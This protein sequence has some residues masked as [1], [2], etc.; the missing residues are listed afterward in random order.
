MTIEERLEYLEQE[1]ASLK[2][3]NEVRAKKFVLEDDNG[4]IRALLG[5]FDGSTGL[6]FYDENGIPRIGLGI[7]TGLFFADEEN[8]VH[9]MLGP[10]SKPYLQLSAENAEINLFMSSV[11]SHLEFKDEKGV[12]RVI[13]GKLGVQP[14]LF[15]YDENDSIRAALTIKQ[16]KTA[17]LMFND[18]GKH[19]VTLSAVEDGAT[20]DLGDN[21]GNLRIR[22]SGEQNEKNLKILGPDGKVIWRAP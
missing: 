13:L 14:T 7:E 9:L 12:S 22:L 3:A 11:G 20:L 4:E 16:G 5:F 2:E 8:D 18:K 1:L 19:C 21:N 10:A 17:F 6:A 15:L